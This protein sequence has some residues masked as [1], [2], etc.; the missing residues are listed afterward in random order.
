MTDTRPR[1]DAANHDAVDNFIDGEDRLSALLR[2][3]PPFEAPATLAV[4]VAT[5]ARAVQARM[6]AEAETSVARVTAP[7]PTFTA[8][9]TLS[10][11]VLREAARLQQAQTT[12]RNAMFDQIDAGQSAQDVLGAP[13]SDA[14]HAWLREQA[15]QHRDAASS[16]A[17][18]PLPRKPKLSRWWKSLGIAASAFAVAGLATQIV[19][20]QLDDGT[21]MTASLSSN[22]MLSDAPPPAT[23]ASP[24]PAAEMAARTNATDDASS[25]RSKSTE[26]TKATESSVASRPAQPV[27]RKSAPMATPP[28]DSANAAHESAREPAAAA[29]AAAPAA[30]PIAFAE[31]APSE[32]APPPAPAPAFV[33]SAPPPPAALRARRAPQAALNAAAPEDS[34]TAD[35]AASIPS[36]IATKS[37]T[38]TIED[39]PAS[40]ALQWRPG[41]ALRIW[42]AEPDNAAVH[43]WVTRLWAAMPAEARPAAPYGIERDETLGRGQLRIAQPP[44]SSP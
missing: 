26:A 39:D 17:P 30:P 7:P 29:A 1:R 42:S 23:V 38:V 20:R 21:P 11:S 14:G 44:S 33:Q 41:K 13:I 2:D 12:R 28:S 3:L 32:P 6:A 18:T 19:L 40:V 34:A 8:P 27:A 35:S 5:A 31:R 15:A 4:S 43:D 37:A 22:V 24:E 25:V 9:P 16:A 10:G 36:A